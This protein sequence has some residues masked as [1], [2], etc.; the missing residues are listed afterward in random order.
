MP[1]TLETFN[2]VGKNALEIKDALLQNRFKESVHSAIAKGINKKE[3]SNKV[4][5]SLLDNKC[6]IEQFKKV[7]LHEYETYTNHKELREALKKVNDKVSPE[8][9]KNGYNEFISDVTIPERGILFNRKMGINVGS[10]QRY[11]KLSAR[12]VKK[13]LTPEFVDKFAL[14]RLTA[15][16]KDAKEQLDNI[17]KAYPALTV[18]T[19]PSYYEEKHGFYNLDIH[20]LLSV[21]E[22]QLEDAD[23]IKKHTLV[24]GEMLAQLNKLYYRIL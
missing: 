15:V 16:G 22:N 6:S 14:L 11:F 3:Y 8:L 24:I 20:I 23:F 21:E 13:V 4:Y 2:E 12:E 9:R 17:S 1:K 10:L 7:L 18:T 19:K 5:K